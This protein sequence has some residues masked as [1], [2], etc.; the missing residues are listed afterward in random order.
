MKI[1][2]KVYCKQS[3]IYDIANNQFN[4]YQTSEYAQYPH[5]KGKWY[6]IYH[7]DESEIYIFSETN[8]SPFGYMNY[9]K[10]RHGL[11]RYGE[12]YHPDYFY[13]YFYTEKEYR[14]LKLQ[15]IQN[16]NKKQKN[17]SLG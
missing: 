10:K 3:F 6:T 13:D 2:D 1:G 8:G 16:I 15:K 17:M 11:S 9:G 5:I 7:I 14:K 12:K 4:N